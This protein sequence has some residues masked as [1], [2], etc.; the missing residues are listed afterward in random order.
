MAQ[1]YVLNLTLLTIVLT[2]RL[3]QRMTSEQPAFLS[4]KALTQ[5]VIVAVLVLVGLAL[6][7]V[8]GSTPQPL[9]ESSI[10]GLG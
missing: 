8:F 9:L 6:F 2:L 10:P 1:G 5:S 7:F 4:R 3:Y